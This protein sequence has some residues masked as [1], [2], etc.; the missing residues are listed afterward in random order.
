MCIVMNREYIYD[1]C[2]VPH[3]TTVALLLNDNSSRQ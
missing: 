2:G 1:Q 3:R